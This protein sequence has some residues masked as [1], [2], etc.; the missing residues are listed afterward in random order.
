MID[1]RAEI[2][3]L[4]GLGGRWPGT[5]AERRA[6]R[7]LEDRLGALGRDC[8]V[9]PTEV[10]PS[11]PLAHAVYALL[12]I[13]G[14]VAS[15]SAPVVG[16]G[17]ALAAVL[18]AFGDATGV[19]MATRRLT[20]RRASQNVVSREGGEKSGVLV[21]VA[22]YDSARTGAIFRRGV[23]ERRAV[24]GN[25]IRRPIG[26]FEPF[27]WSLV[28]VLVCCLLRL[29]GFEG[30]ALTAIQFVP[31]ALLIVS[32]PLLVD[33]ALSGV[34][35]GA[36]DN[37]SGVATV[38]RLA[39]AH[40]GRLEHFDLW[41]LLTGAEE[42]FALGMRAFLKRH[43][44]SLAKARTVFVNIDEVGFGTVRYARREGLVVA[45]RSHVQLLEICD[46][47]ADDDE[48]DDAFGARRLVSRTTSDGF[49]AR[50]AG[51]PAITI[52]CRNTLDYTPHHHLASDV[53]ER[54]EEAALERAYGF[55]SEL[56]QRLD[57]QVGPELQ[58]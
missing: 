24:L 1:A 8:R 6:A 4:A 52:S 37:A 2:E 25:L 36:N 38:L 3:S 44:K 21:L 31:T 19:F 15:V 11:Y 39:E 12:A 50:L 49:T 45:V 42:G 43:R 13:A 40:G 33:I 10:W 32:V 53:P 41:V 29:P 9:E 16:A 47:I 55:A 28:A 35:P 30:T 18:L 57:A 5:D 58:A 48:D 27:F 20:G 23:Q 46:E 34:V 54:L 7:H 17:L 51:Y 56:V 26:P 14:S 22:H